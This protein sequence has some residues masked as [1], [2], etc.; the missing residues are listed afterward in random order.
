MGSVK[1]VFY[2]E[3]ISILFSRN[4][5][6][7]LSLYGARVDGFLMYRGWEYPGRTKMKFFFLGEL[8]IYLIQ[9]LHIPTHACVVFPIHLSTGISTTTSLLFSSSESEP[10][11][12]SD[13]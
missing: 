1:G 11:R 4:G 9:V 3:W 8:A 12:E 5:I 7:K 6:R 13:M 2:E 10:D